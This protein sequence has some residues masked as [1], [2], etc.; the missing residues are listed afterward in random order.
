MTF[1][2]EIASC[3]FIILIVPLQ[4]ILL[5]TITHKYILND[6][7]KNIYYIGM[8]TNKHN[9]TESADQVAKKI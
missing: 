8:I 3:L 2:F 5:H 6:Q 1:A 9:Q 4:F 7:N